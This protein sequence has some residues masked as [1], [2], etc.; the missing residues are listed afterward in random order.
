LVRKTREAAKKI[1]ENN[2]FNS[3]LESKLKDFQKNI[4]L[5]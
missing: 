5:E 1:L 4:H 2:L 3:T